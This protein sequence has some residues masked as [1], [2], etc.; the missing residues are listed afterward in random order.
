MDFSPPPLRVFT[1][2]DSIREDFVFHHYF[3]ARARK[4]ALAPEWAGTM[5]NHRNCAVFIGMDEF[6]H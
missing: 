6:V 4:I 2:G 1:C 5:R 3:F